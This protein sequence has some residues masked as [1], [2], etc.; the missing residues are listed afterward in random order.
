MLSDCVDNYT[1][2]KTI[3]K[4]AEGHLARPL[5]ELVRLIKADLKE[6]QNAEDE[7]LQKELQLHESL[8][9]K[10]QKYRMSIGEKLLEAKTH[11]QMKHGQFKPWIATNFPRLNYQSAKEYM[12]MVQLQKVTGVTFSGP[13]HYR[14]TKWKKTYAANPTGTANWRNHV[15]ARLDAFEAQKFNIE[16]RE[17]DREKEQKLVNDLALEIISIG[18]K[19]L[20]TKM[21]PDKGTGSHEAMRRLNA[22]RDLLKGV[23]Q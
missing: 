11:P 18:Y 9:Q 10:T 17:S 20:A 13:Q 21:H 8:E 3:D 12:G 5:S 22:A 6:M 4:Q 14:A 16:R 15:Q 2:M 7:V 19:V 23:V 1:Q